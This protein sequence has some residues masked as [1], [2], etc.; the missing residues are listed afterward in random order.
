MLI[1]ILLI[2]LILLASS[3]IVYLIITLK[4]LNQSIGKLN[5]DV[6][7]LIETTI[8]VLENL[9]AASKKAVSVAEDAER[10]MKNFNSF[11]EKT[12]LK[13]TS[14]AS[15]VK[16]GKDKNPVLN[17][18]NNLNAFSKGIGAFWNKLNNS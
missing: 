1:D 8:P 3:L 7:R 4:K 6:S 5:N 13:I 10:H 18:I 12:K 16:E 2:I 17:L 9:D 15:T 14:V 11:V